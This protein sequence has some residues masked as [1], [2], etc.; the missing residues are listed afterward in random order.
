MNRPAGLALLLAAAG[1]AAP[2]S[3][4]AADPAERLDRIRIEI[5]A[6]EAR[7][8][9]FSEEAEGYLGEL[10]AIDRELAETRRSLRRLRLRQHGAEEELGQ[11][12]AALAVAERARMEVGEALKVRMVALYKFRSTGG[13]PALASARDFQSF[14]RLGRSLGQILEADGALF[15]RY[16]SAEASYR[17][18]QAEAADL[19]AEL[20]LAAREIS[21]REDRS[22]RKAV[23]RRN[24]VA[25]L[26]SR[27]DREQRTAAELREA[28]ARLEE[29]IRELPGSP[30]QAG[31]G[32]VRG[33]VR[34]PLDGP[35]RLGFGRQVDPEFGTETLRTG[36]EFAGVRGRPVRAVAA[37]R[38]LFAGWFRGYGQIV[39]VDHGRS[40]LTVSG[41]LQELSVAKND[42]VNAGQQIGTVGETGALSGPGLYFE[43]RLDG[44]AVDPDL[45]L[46]PR[47]EGIQ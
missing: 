28:A 33:R 46:T 4:G 11:A 13:L 9:S 17:A 18:S 36:V 8:R 37:G 2:A 47:A 32:L 3:T 25:L 38:V 20:E 23:E 7:A 42:T 1:A 29:A 24:L 41:Y 40:I 16:R 21:R 30:R 10:E 12:R 31:P 15:A 45:W 26:R 39:I 44:R 6:R 34:P 27:A 43:I 14:A 5:E 19:A 35:I 22:R